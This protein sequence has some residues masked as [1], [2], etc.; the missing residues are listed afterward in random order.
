MKKIAVISQKGGVGKTTTSLAI[1]HGA[2]LRGWRVLG[3]DCDA[4]ENFTLSLDGMEDDGRN[5]AGV[6]LNDAPMSDMIVS[7]S[8]PDTPLI[9]AAILKGSVDVSVADVMMTGADRLYRLRNALDSVS[10]SYDITVMDTPP[11]V[12]VLSLS[13]MVAADVIVVPVNADTY[14]LHALSQLAGTIAMVREKW[15]P[16]LKVAGLLLTKFDAR[17]SLSND[18]AA[19]ISDAAGILGTTA[20]SLPIREAV[21]CKEAI[22]LRRALDSY[23]PKA[24]VTADYRT[25]LDE[26][27]ERCDN[28]KA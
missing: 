17:S 19:A 21:A 3:I 14:G 8:D 10:E 18:M 2:R 25:F 28:G 9:P 7:Y 16:S 22:A 15:N 6:L 27:F 11:G 23:A 5:I 24:K 13:A 4:Q 12:G 1:F 20:F 26:L